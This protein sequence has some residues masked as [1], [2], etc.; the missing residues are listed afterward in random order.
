MHS[1]Q[2]GGTT[3]AGAVGRPGR[4]RVCSEQAQGALVRVWAGGQHQTG[5]RRGAEPGDQR[6]T[7]CGKAS[8]LTYWAPLVFYKQEHR[9]SESDSLAQ[10]VQEVVAP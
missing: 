5:G 8:K 9:A 4:G 1:V 6:P 10:L 2:K 3:R 7:D